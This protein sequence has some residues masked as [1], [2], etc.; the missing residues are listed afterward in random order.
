MNEKEIFVEEYLKTKERFVLSSE[1]IYVIMK[2]FP[3]VNN[4]Y[5]RKIISNL[6]KKGIITSSCPITFSNNNFAYASKNKKVNYRNLEDLI[7]QEK[8]QLYRAICLMR[9]E[10]N[11]ITY[12]ELAKVTGCPISCVGNN[13]ILDDIIYDLLYFGIVQ[14]IEYK[15]ITFFASKKSFNV[16]IDKKIL[17]LKKENRILVMLINWLKESNIINSDD[18]VTFKGEKNCYKGVE[19]NKILWDAFF[20]T[21]TVGRTYNQNGKKTIGVIDFLYASKYDLI[22]V[23]GFKSRVDIIINSTKKENS[24]RKVLPIILADGITNAAKKVIKENNYICFDIKRIIGNNYEKI[25]S[26]Y[27]ELRKN[28]I[29]DINEIDKICNLIGENANYGNMKG[30]LFEYII[31]DILRKIY[32]ESGTN[33]EHSININGREIDYRVETPKENIFFELK[34]YKK[35]CEIELGN[36]SQEYTVNWS[37]KGT[38]QMFVDKYKNDPNNRKCKFCYITTSKFNKQAIDML[39]KLNS[40]KCKPDK[41]DCYYDRE[42][43]LYLLKENDCKNEIKIIKKYY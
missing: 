1:L 4:N 41:M 36:E 42:K 34:S 25:I 3:M 24:N 37:Y 7:R 15:G 17:N 13:I 35:D 21:E 12:N 26:K 38:Y 16:D 30:K 9:R 22:D 6:N 27:L 39:K 32:N 14:K 43:L 18:L 28:D 10:R 33:F 40:G 2:E 31:G 19:D 8:K 29:Y 20:Y 5:A 23:E 11:I